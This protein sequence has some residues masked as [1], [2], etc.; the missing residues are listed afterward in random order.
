MGQPGP[1]GG[2]GRPASRLVNMTMPAMKIRAHLRA[3]WG[4]PT[5]LTTPTQRF[6]TY[7]DKLTW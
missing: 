4:K 6:R 5:K 7:R 1:L 3:D 2:S